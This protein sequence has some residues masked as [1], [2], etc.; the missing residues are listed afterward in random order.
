MKCIN[1]K[2]ICLLL[3]LCTL[4]FS[5]CGNTVESVTFSNAY[6]IYETSKK[7]QLISTEDTS[8]H[9][10][11]PYF[12]SNNCV[13]DGKDLG[14]DKT[15][16]YVAGASGVFNLTTKD[17]L[18][19]Q[20]IYAKMYPA[21]TTKILTAYVALKYGDLNGIY[22]VSENAADQASDS[23]VCNL[24]AGEQLS[25]QQ[26]LYGLLLRSG[27]DAAIVIAE[28][29][30]GDVSSFAELMN[31]EAKMLGA[32]DSHFVNANGLQDENHYTTVYDL[33]LIF[34][35][36]IQNPTFVDIIHTTEYTVDYLDPNGMSIQQVWTS[37]NKYLMG[38]ETAPDGITVIGGKTGTTNDAGYCLVL[39][40]NNA[41]GDQIVSIVMKADCR[42]NLYYYM[43]EL[44]RQA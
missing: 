4:I 22:T 38:T 20:N 35:A 19:A 14:T 36:A 1:K 9:G 25:L 29:I 12:A 7:Y 15:S 23:S 30:S 11:L 17:V 42:N 24:K 37:T 10:A 39:L 13:S 33:Y 3:L 32:T 8:L 16:S 26:L 31:K 44:L 28:G 6:D 18:Y 41:A 2:N 43:N 5:G 27:N 21:S 40:S 34:Q